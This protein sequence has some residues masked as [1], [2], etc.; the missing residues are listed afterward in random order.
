LL[1]RPRA[2]RQLSALAAKA[3]A[4]FTSPFVDRI[5][6][7]QSDGLGLIEDI[8]GI[9]PTYHYQP[10]LLAASVRSAD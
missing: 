6:Y 9:F 8:V 2:E 4:T 3:G 1:R 7:I 10:K 5:T